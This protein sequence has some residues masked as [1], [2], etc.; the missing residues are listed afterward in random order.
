MLMPFLELIV[1][2]Q[3][4]AFNPEQEEYREL[5]GDVFKDMT[6]EAPKASETDRGLSPTPL[7]SESSSVRPITPKSS[8]TARPGEPVQSSPP[9]RALQP[10][11]EFNKILG[12]LR[13]IPTKPDKK[14]GTSIH[15]QTEFEIQSFQSTP[16]ETN[17]LR[18]EV[19]IKRQGARGRRYFFGSLKTWCLDCN[20]SREIAK[21]IKVQVIMDEGHAQIVIRTD[22][23]FGV[24]KRYS[25]VLDHST[26]LSQY[27]GLRLLSYRDVK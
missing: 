2:C 14:S 7:L 12:L 20:A 13:R 9:A 24:A 6:F 27:G 11:E 10:Y 22:R 21:I 19:T 1:L 17:P 8:N 23:P 3:G 25:L 18:I 15:Y 16:T 4:S 5:C 26:L